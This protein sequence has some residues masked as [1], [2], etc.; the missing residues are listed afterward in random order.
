MAEKNKERKPICSASTGMK[1]ADIQVWRFLIELA[2]GLNS[3]SIYC[4]PVLLFASHQ[5][6]QKYIVIIGLDLVLSNR[7]PCRGRNVLCLNH[8][9]LPST[10]HM[11]SSTWA[12]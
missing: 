9:C 2:N 8:V 6:L 10:Q 1:W 5:I 3:L 12:F 11:T 4:F 7:T